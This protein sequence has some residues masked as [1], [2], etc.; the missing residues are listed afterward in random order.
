MEIDQRNFSYLYRL[1]EL[2]ED[3]KEIEN[4]FQENKEIWNQIVEEELANPIKL[5]LLADK[6]E[7]V[8]IKMINIKKII[9]AIK[10]IISN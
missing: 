1:I 7:S 2:E 9:H 5:T 6:M 10:L 3:Y 8:R 4:L